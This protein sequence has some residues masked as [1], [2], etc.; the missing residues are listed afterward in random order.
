[1]RLQQIRY[2]CR[3]NGHDF[4]APSLM[5]GYGVWTVRSEASGEARV[6]DMFDSPT[7]SRI[8]NLAAAALPDLSDRRRGELQQQ[9]IAALAD[10]D[11]NGHRFAL[12]GKP[13]CPVC[14]STA[15]D[16][17][18]ATGEQLEGTIPAAT[19]AEVEALS[20]EGLEAAIHAVLEQLLLWP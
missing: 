18:Q 8:G 5:G 4:Q 9:T 14:G 13:L 16:T 17:W 2:T 20:A 19:F 10:P 11:E 12:D 1:M 15:A 3:V 7:A 6:V